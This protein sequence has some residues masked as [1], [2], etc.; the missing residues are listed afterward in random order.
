MLMFHDPIPV[1][2]LF[3]LIQIYTLLLLHKSHRDIQQFNLFSKP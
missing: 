3:D 2:F 1:S